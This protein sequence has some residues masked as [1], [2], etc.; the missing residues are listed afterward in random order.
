MCFRRG[1][2]SVMTRCTQ[3]GS[4][5]LGASTAPDQLVVAGQTFTAELSALRCNACGAVFFDGSAVGEFERAVARELARRGPATGETFQFMRKALAL[6]SMDLAE[7]LD[8][9]HETLAR[10]ETGKLPISRASWIAVSSLVLD[11]EGTRARLRAV[12]ES[13][14]LASPEVR[15]DVPRAAAR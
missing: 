10:W 2:L 12:Q 9:T 4:D 14:N 15:L 1:K 13:P 3:C 7:M 8:V 11:Y 6:R 5:Q